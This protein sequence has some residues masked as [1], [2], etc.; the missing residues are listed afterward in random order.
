MWVYARHCINRAPPLDHAP[1][2]HIRTV[3]ADPRV[4]WRA[5]RNRKHFFSLFRMAAMHPRNSR[6]VT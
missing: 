3:E 5:C 6:I 1:P 4:P 2:R